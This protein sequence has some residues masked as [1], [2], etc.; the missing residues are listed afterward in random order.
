MTLTSFSELA[1]LA[2]SLEATS[3]RKEKTRLLADFLR[4]L[5][6]EEVAPAVLLVVGS[7]FPEFDS[8]TMEVGWRTMKGA[9]EGRKQTTL[10]SEPLTIL[11][12]NKILE[13]IA[14][15][16]GQ[17]SRRIKIGLLQGLLNEADPEDIDILVRIIFGEMR[18][19]VNEGVMTEGIA[20]AAGVDAPARIRGH[21]AH[22]RGAC[23][24]A[25]RCAGPC[26]PSPG[27]PR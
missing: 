7:I 4:R 14:E 27:G 5:E 12:V 24:P 16:G 10:F 26:C 6:L 21:E 18:I 8:R 11:K 20:E 23:A 22:P 19:G 1:G 15:T 3:K 13:K 25:P 17:G 9:L 2:R